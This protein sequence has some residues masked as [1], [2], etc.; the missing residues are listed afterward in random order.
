MRLRLAIQRHL[1]PSVD[2]LWSVNTSNPR[3]TLTVAQLI[4]QV[5]EVIP[6]EHDQWGLEDYIAEVKGYECI[7]HFRVRDVLRDE[8][9]VTYVVAMDLFM[10]FPLKPP[11]KN[12]WIEFREY[13]ED[14]FLIHKFYTCIRTEDITVESFLMNCL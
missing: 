14:V 1:L 10:V 13:D 11:K 9:E 6:L 7:H 12:S 8:D 4:E 5:N 3:T 2:I